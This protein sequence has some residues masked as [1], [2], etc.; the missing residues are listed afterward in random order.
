MNSLYYLGLDVHKKTISYCLKLVDGSIVA[1]GT[2]STQRKSL[3]AWLR[4]LPKPWCGAMEAT[5]FTGWIYDFLL[6]HAKS[7][8]V[9]H[10]AMLKAISASKKKNDKVDA[11]MLADLL[12]CNLLPVC[13]MAPPE[14][15]ELRRL[16][17]YRSLMVRQAVRMKNKTAGLLMEV[18][19]EY[20]KEKL[21]QAG[22]FR[23]LLETVEEV[24]DSVKDLLKISRGAAELFD[25]AQ[26]RLVLGL[27]R[28]PLLKQRVERLRSIRGV[29]EILALTWA[30][31]VGE[32]SRFPTVGHA[33][34][35]CGLTSAQISSAGKEQ[36]APISKQRNKH[37]QTILIE[38]A[39]VAPLWNPQLKLV[40]EREKNRG[41]PNRATLAVAR[42]LVAYLL[43]VDRSGQQFQPRAIAEKESRCLE[44]QV[45]MPAQ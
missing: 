1:E 36:R 18:G 3:E 19:A 21:H 17:R 16:L 5:L 2:V 34:S 45:A 8:Q 30:V 26:R 32:P 14:L 41:N 9:A 42:K 44:E 39:K 13:Y 11:R 27:L 25:E 40:H 23:D 6:P 28:N 7:L 4:Q 22:Y 24:P 12:R 10:P 38:A 35:Y 43:A 33:L 37:L 20:N 29:G 15:R 31:E